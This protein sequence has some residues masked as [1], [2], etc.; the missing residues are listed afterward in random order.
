MQS[1]NLNTIYIQIKVE[2]I[3]ILWMG[4]LFYFTVV[5]QV[6]CELWTIYNHISNITKP[7]LPEQYR[8]E[9]TRLLVQPGLYTRVT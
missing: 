8:P 1:N 2:I 7:G 4:I 5:L 3:A 9:T 6:C